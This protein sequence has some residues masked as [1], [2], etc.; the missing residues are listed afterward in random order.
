M[1]NNTHIRKTLLNHFIL[2]LILKYSFY[3]SGDER[4]DKET[5][6]PTTK[7][8]E[9]KEE[10]TNKGKHFFFNHYNTFVMH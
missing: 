2:Y 9:P 10:T 8:T 5:M 4:H 7:T 6:I 1:I 3:K